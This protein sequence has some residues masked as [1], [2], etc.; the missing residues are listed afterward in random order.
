VRALA[1]LLLAIA[2]PAL[3]ACNA[4]AASEQAQAPALEFT[5]RVVDAAGILDDAAEAKLTTQ[6]AALEKEVGPH[7]VV[8]TTPSLGGRKI[9][10]YSHDLGNAWGVGDKKRDDGLLLVIAPNDRKVRIQLGTGL[11][12]VLSDELCSNIIVNDILPALREGAFADGAASGVARLDYE[13]RAKLQKR[14]AV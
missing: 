11:E 10:D 8:V 3:A 6:L 4:T 12:S 9:E 13:L 14:A 5:G 1:P 7:V 2:S